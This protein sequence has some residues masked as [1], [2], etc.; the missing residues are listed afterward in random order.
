MANVI[1]NPTRTSTT[2]PGTATSG[3]VWRAEIGTWGTNGQSLYSV[4]KVDNDQVTIEMETA[5]QDV[6]AV[7]NST[8]NTATFPGL[9]FR[10]SSTTSNYWVE[11]Q[12]DGSLE[13]YR[14]LNGL[15][16][17]NKTATGLYT[18]GKALRALATDDGTTL[19]IKTYVDGVLAQ[20][21]TDTT[22][23]RPSGTRA[24]FRHGASSSNQDIRWDT[25]RFNMVVAS[26]GLA[27]TIQSIGGIT[28]NAA[29]TSMSLS[30]SSAPVAKRLLVTTISGDKT[31]PSPVVPSGWTLGGT[32]TGTA[33]T[34]QARA[35]KEATGAET[36]VTWS[37]S[38]GR[39]AAMWIGEFGLYSFALANSNTNGTESD[40][41]TLSINS[42]AATSGGLRFGF[43]AIDSAGTGATSWPS[44]GPTWSGVTKILDVLGSTSINGGS[45]LSVAY[46]ES[47][48][49]T[50]QTVTISYSG[51]PDQM[52]LST[53]TFSGSLT[54]PTTGN[55]GTAPTTLIRGYKASTLSL[56]NGAA[57][58]NWAA[59]NGAETLAQ[60]TSAN[61]P[62]YVASVTEFGNKPGVL[63]NAS[64]FLQATTS[65]SNQPVTLVLV[66][67]TNVD[68]D[69]QAIHHGSELLATAQKWVGYSGNGGLTS[70]ATTGP[71]VVTYVANGASSAIYVNG[72]LKASGTSG[73]TGLNTVLR[74]GLHTDGSRQFLRTIAEYREYGSALT[75]AERS[76]VHSEMQNAYG[77]A[78]SDYS[79]SATGGMKQRRGGVWSTAKYK[80]NGVWTTGPKIRKNGTWN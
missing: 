24:G 66:V 79:T 44:G 58:A 64:D 57:V 48:A 14:N 13:V 72:T 52:A 38:G 78:V 63:F 61:Q 23:G 20:T 35:Y 10:W 68:G 12:Q 22:S 50:A 54:A 21:I 15:T 32:W 11:P 17:L 25:I 49:N 31:L 65:A 3:Q 30:Y 51:T 5:Q 73:T 39:G 46:S 27:P 34:G 18:T 47:I 7:L 76:S 19:T 28:A 70:T 9:M 74:M 36:S 6:S 55:T 59:T 42:A 33:G 71:Q 41:S 26:G 45:A 60:A 80:K 1:D 43:A 62:Q 2:S 53:A 69:E 77:I 37:W 67:S 29:S 40:V 75:A 8:L 16:L 4:T 56:A